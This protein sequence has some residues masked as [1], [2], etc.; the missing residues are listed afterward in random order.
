MEAFKSF[1]GVRLSEWTD[2]DSRKEA[3][4]LALKDVSDTLTADEIYSHLNAIDT[5][6]VTV[7]VKQSIVSVEI[8]PWAFPEELCEYA[9]TT[10]NKNGFVDISCESVSEYGTQLLTFENGVISEKLDLIEM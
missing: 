2:I 9:F 6:V 3:F 5:G 10:L 4:N 7:S 1:E 8:F